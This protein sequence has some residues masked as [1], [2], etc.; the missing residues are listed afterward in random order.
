MDGAIVAIEIGNKSYK[1]IVELDPVSGWVVREIAGLPG[2]HTQ[3]PDMPALQIAMRKAIDVY[4]QTVGP[5]G[6]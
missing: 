5:A 1:M 2:C 6:G 3:A 4:L